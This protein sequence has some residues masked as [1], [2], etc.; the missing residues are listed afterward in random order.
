[1]YETIQGLPLFKGTTTE[2]ISAF[3]EKTNV[4]FVNF[5]PGQVLAEAG[6]QCA[7][8]KFVIS[9]VVR[10]ETSLAEGRAVLETVSGYGTVLS[11]C[12]LFGLHTH[13]PASVTSLEGGSYM[14]IRKD[15]YLD[16]LHNDTIYLVNYLNYLSFNAQRSRMALCGMGG[17]R[18][19]SWL[20]AI[21]S[22]LVERRCREARVRTTRAD[23]AAV[24]DMSV[25]EL[26]DELVGLSVTGD[27]EIFIDV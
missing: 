25:S 20:E 11:P 26:E 13:Y 1:M 10:S 15:Q 19:H 7:D 23:L 21:R 17:R 6:K 18:L 3:L 5:T 24:L 2:H 22:G 12:N 8:L 16:L 14:Q 27:L 9:G 4:E